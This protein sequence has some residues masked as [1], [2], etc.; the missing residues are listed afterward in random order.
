MAGAHQ[1]ACEGPECSRSANSIGAPPL[2]DGR[3]RLAA[4]YII[5]NTPVQ[6]GS[7]DGLKRALLLLVPQLRANGAIVS[8]VHD[9]LVVECGTPDAETVKAT[10]ENCMSA[11]MSQ[12]FPGVR[13]AVEGRIS[14]TWGGE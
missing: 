1:A 10:V 9:E 13:I 14:Q 3:F 6:G 2:A 4:V 5:T 7:G 11:A 8:T 12:L